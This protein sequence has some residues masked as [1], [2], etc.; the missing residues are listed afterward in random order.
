[1]LL[2]EFAFALIFALTLEV[3]YLLWRGATMLFEQVH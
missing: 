2:L 3:V 1:M